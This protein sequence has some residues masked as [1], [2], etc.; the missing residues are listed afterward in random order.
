MVRGM[1]AIPVNDSFTPFQKPA[2]RCFSASNSAS[3]KRLH[4]NVDAGIHNPEHPGRHPEGRYVGHNGER[5]RGA[6]GPN[7]EEGAAAAPARAP[8]AVG[9][10]ADDG[11]HEQAGGGG[12]YPK[13]SQLVFLRAHRFE[14]AAHV[15]VLQRKAKLDAQEAEAH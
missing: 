13:K 8:G 10:V 11:L 12:R 2:V 5:Q 1:S 3:S 14:D 6:D 15:A 9:E 4:R 7:Q